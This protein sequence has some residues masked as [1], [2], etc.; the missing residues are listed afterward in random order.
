MKR[1]LLLP[2]LAI[3]S[4]IAL[5]GCSAADAGATDS[6][7]AAWTY[8]DGSGTTVALDEVPDRII[9][10]AN[11]AAALIPLGIRPVGIYVD[12]PVEDDRSLEGLDLTGIEIVGEAWGEIDIEKVA[13]LQPDLIIAEW[14]PTEEAYSGLEDRTSGTGKKI[15]D[16]APIV[17]VSQGPSIATMIE[18]YE[19]L[20]ES[21]GADLSEPS[22]DES[23]TAFEAAVDRFKTVAASKPNLSVLAVSPSPEALYVAVPQYAAELSDFSAWGMNLVVP[24]KPDEGFVYWQ[25]LSWEAADT[26]QADLIIIDDRSKRA[27]WKDAEAQ[28]TWTTL[29]AAAAGAITDWPAY[30]L[31]NYDAYA[32]ELDKLSDAMESADENLVTEG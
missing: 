11:A 9:A 19:T 17:G 16:L 12:S 3:A 18:D 6:A 27:N 22:I 29:S 7:S 32:T 25:T 4:M 15:L 1:P 26:Y 13:A 28:P 5:A 21:L 20:A 23:R 31:R 2:A 14:W 24:E 10:H 8:T 30:W